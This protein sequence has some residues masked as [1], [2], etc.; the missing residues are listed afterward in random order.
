MIMP[1]EQVD[2]GMLNRIAEKITHR[3]PQAKGLSG[4]LLEAA[5]KEYNSE[6]HSD[7]TPLSDRDLATLYA[8]HARPEVHKMNLPGL[9]EHTYTLL[10]EYLV[11]RKVIQPIV[12]D[13]Q[14]VNQQA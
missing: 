12:E 5:R 6:F 10:Y 3:A 2:Y 13:S 1:F 4:K 8:K 7:P 11:E 9:G 14:A